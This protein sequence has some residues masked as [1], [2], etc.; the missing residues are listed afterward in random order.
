MAYGD[1]PST[2][3][4][5]VKW[6]RGGLPGSTASVVLNTGEELGN[7]ANVEDNKTTTSSIFSS[8]AVIE[9]SP[10]SG[11]EAMKK[12]TLTATVY[13]YF[14]AWKSSGNTFVFTPKET[15]D[16]GDDVYYA[17]NA[18]LEKLDVESRVDSVIT[19]TISGVD[20]EFTRD[21]ASD[22]RIL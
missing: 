15:P 10:T 12:V 6:T 7:V 22:I 1:T 3:R 2:H 18:G 13:A 19:V 4:E 11:Y 9:I 17:T 20:T 5:I 8:P 14:Y 16:A 21:T